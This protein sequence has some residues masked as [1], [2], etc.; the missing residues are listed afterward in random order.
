MI[1]LRLLSTGRW[2]EWRPW[3]PATV[4]GWLHEMVAFSHS[5]QQ[6]FPVRPGIKLNGPLVGMAATNT[7][8]G[9]WLV[10]ADGGVFS[11]GDAVF[12]AD[13]LVT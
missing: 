7:G 6:N 5:E 8:A 12:A 3:S 1:W 2:Q 4:T 13:Q 9:Y 10:A 11:F